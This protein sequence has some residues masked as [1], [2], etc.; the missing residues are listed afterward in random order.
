MQLQEVGI[1]MTELTK[2]QIRHRKIKGDLSKIDIMSGEVKLLRE[3]LLILRSCLMEVNHDIFSK[4][5]SDRS[6]MKVYH[7]LAG[8]SNEWVIK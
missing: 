4:V 2:S 1:K 3:H 5:R 7:R 6:C 8:Y